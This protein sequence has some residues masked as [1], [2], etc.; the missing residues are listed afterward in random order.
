MFST[1]GRALGPCPL[2]CTPA[3]PR[4]STTSWGRGRPAGHHGYPGPDH[5][6][7]TT[8]IK[9]PYSDAFVTTPSRRLNGG[10]AQR[11]PALG[12]SHAWAN[13]SSSLVQKAEKRRFMGVA[14]ASRTGA[15]PKRPHASATRS[16]TTA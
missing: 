5:S 8:S 14:N 10:I 15:I 4:G 7:A 13:A 9:Q 3:G 12:Q 16:G 6:G 1:V 2:A 11:A